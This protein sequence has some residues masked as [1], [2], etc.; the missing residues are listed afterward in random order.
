MSWDMGDLPSLINIA[1]GNDY[2]RI[3]DQGVA[4]TLTRLPRQLL[5]WRRPPIQC[6]GVV[7]S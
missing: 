1:N 6:T 2:Y 5:A 7:C 4:V 3:W